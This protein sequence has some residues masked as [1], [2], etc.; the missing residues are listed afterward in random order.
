MSICLSSRFQQIS[1]RLS[2]KNLKHSTISFWREIREDYDRLANLCKELDSNISPLILLSY[3]LNMF[4]LLIQLYHS[5]ESISLVTEKI[6]F[7]YS[8]SFLIYKTT[9][10]S[11]YAARIN[12]ESKT[13][14]TI[15][16]SVDSSLYNV[17]IRRLLTQISLDKTALTGCKLFTITRGLI[18]SVAS[19]VVTYEL[20]LIQFSSANLY[21]S[22]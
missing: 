1:K 4:Y 2:E 18:L 12:D 20:V 22:T 11:L 8:F 19:A 13:P 21:G 3:S 17:E 16:N 6:Y 9:S 7:A 10:V 14:T 15:L 5:L